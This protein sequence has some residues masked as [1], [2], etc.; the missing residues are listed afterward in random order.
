MICPCGFCRQ[1]NVLVVVGLNILLWIVLGLIF[2][3]VLYLVMVVLQFSVVCLVMIFWASILAFFPMLA[4]CS[5]YVRNSVGLRGSGGIL[6]VCMSC[7]FRIFGLLWRY[8]GM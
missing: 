2:S 4:S 6:G 5:I 7:R 3:K 1:S 8:G